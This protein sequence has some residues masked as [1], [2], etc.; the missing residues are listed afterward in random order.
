MF[1]GTMA[2]GGIVVYIMRMDTLVAVISSS[3]T[4]VSNDTCYTMMIRVWEQ[5]TEQYIGDWID[6]T[7]GSEDRGIIAL[8]AR[9]QAIMKMV[10]GCN[11][12]LGDM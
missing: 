6:Q 11:N 12:V 5:L 9:E 4:N 3:M 7:I 10:I 1:L 8:A 2:R